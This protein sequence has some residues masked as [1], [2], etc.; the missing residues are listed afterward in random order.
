MQ[1]VSGDS[2]AA[3]DASSDQHRLL[4]ENNSPQAA[5]S[6]GA[7]AH[8]QSSA[9]T[10]LKKKA[11]ALQW[12]QRV[13]E[14][15]AR[16]LRRI[17]LGS[18]L[19]LPAE[20]P[21]K[22]HHVSESKSERV[23]V[24]SPQEPFVQVASLEAVPVGELGR[25][26]LALALPD[27]LPFAVLSVLPYVDTRRKRLFARDAPADNARLALRSRRF[28][29]IVLII[30][31]FFLIGCI[32]VLGREFSPLPTHP[33]LILQQNIRR[34]MVKSWMPSLKSMI[35]TPWM[36][37]VGAA[38]SFPAS[39]LFPRLSISHRD[40]TCSIPHFESPSPRQT[41][42]DTRT[43][44]VCHDRHAL[45]DTSRAETGAEPAIQGAVCARG[46]IVLKRGASSPG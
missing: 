5:A 22:P 43:D 15:A 1:G 42:E 20:T 16:F 13:K 23:H 25:S 24:P 19:A 31:N 26:R 29:W 34:R 18:E 17:S 44:V 36:T 2:T 41:P 14:D 4:S 45:C 40:L 37:E 27:G 9:S 12:H 7:L 21:T 46:A 10:F 28:G 11:Q 38:F 39:H 32:V 33:H 30:L 6:T 8:S 3:D 35:P